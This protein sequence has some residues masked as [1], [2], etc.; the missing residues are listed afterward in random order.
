MSQSYSPYSPSEPVRINVDAF[1]AEAIQTGRPLDISSIWNR[2]YALVM[3]DYWTFFITALVGGLCMQVI[4]L[5][6][7]VAGGLFYYFLGRI[8]NQ[9]REFSDLF[10]GFNQMTL[11]LILVGAVAG[12]LQCIGFLFLILQ[13]I[14]LVLI[15]FFAYEL[16]IDKRL[17]FWD[18]M[19]VSRKVV[20]HQ[21][22]NV[23]VLWLVVALIGFIGFLCRLIGVYFVLPFIWAMWVYAYEDL[24][25]GMSSSNPQPDL[26]F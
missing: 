14:Y 21:F 3:S 24:F 23:L 7:L 9:R 6:F 19:E 16:V 5:N 20:H 10:I 8:R 13:G 22:G 17:Q 25:G 11:Q 1:V 12:T 2:A 26:T 4:V 18:A 15:W